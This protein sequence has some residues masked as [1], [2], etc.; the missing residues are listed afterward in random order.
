MVTELSMGRKIIDHKK[1]TNYLPIS[2]LCVHTGQQCVAELE[3]LTLNSPTA[4][5]VV[6]K[7]CV[8]SKH[9]SML[10]VV[11]RLYRGC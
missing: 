1:N 4:C 10:L 2:S 8:E 9:S 6:K 11:E 7:A 3:N 5:H